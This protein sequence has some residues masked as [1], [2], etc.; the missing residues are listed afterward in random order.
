MLFI[1]RFWDLEGTK[2]RVDDTT[3]SKILRDTM[4]INDDG[5]LWIPNVNEGHQG[6]WKCSSSPF[7]IKL[8]LK[9]KEAKIKLAYQGGKLSCQIE[10]FQKGMEIEWLHNGVQIA[11]NTQ[12]S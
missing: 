1:I 2:I 4:R 3:E 9:A 7:R 5:S 6:V 12:V 8:D 11:E 10:N